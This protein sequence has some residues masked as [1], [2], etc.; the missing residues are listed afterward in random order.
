MRLVPGAGAVL[1]ALALVPVAAGCSDDDPAAARLAVTHRFDLSQGI[2][3]EGFVSYLRLTQAD[4]EVVGQRELRGPLPDRRA[5]FQLPEGDYRLIAYQRTCAGNCGF[6]DPPS[7]RC[8]EE[9]ALRGGQ[10]RRV[11]VAVAF[12]DGDRCSITAR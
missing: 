10:A 12:G 3:T 5:T 7:N 1:I 6:L 11:V 8:A 2:P 9:L 4:G